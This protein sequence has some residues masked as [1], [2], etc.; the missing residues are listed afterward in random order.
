MSLT[1]PMMTMTTYD[2]VITS[3]R[4]DIKKSCFATWTGT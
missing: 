1:I 2:N 4:N 3:I